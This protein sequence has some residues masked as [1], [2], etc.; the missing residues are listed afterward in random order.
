LR[1]WIGRASETL[2]AGRREL[3][4]CLDGTGMRRRRNMVML[5]KHI[6]LLEVIPPA[7]DYLQ[8]SKRR[9][10]G[11]YDITG[12]DAFERWLVRSFL[13]IFLAL[14]FSLFK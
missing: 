14:S 10:D 5:M 8:W 7:Y 1:C 11:K 9:R 2:R 3:A 4:C 12:L 6:A 13:I